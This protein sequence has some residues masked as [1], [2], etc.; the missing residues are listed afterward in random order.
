MIIFSCFYGV[1]RLF[2][3]QGPKPLLSGRRS[4]SDTATKYSQL[5]RPS[6]PLLQQQASAGMRELLAEDMS[7]NFDVIKLEKITDKRWFTLGGSHAF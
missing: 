1:S 7:W 5:P 3:Q 2:P 4:S 6:L